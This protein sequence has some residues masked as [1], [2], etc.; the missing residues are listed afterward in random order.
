MYS[1]DV[2]TDS[3]RRLETSEMWIW[4]RMEKI[5]CLGKVTEEVFRRV[6][7]DR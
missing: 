7:E 3:D 6:N 5:S 2:N 1:R 4:R